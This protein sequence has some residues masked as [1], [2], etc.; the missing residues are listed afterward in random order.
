MAVKHT[1]EDWPQ[2]RRF[3]VR[4]RPCGDLKV[5]LETPD[6]IS[7]TSLSSLRARL[8]ELLEGYRVEMET[9]DFLPGNLAGKHRWIV[10][11]MASQQS[12]ASNVDSVLHL[13]QHT[14]AANR[15]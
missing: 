15:R 2:I 9:V 7:E 3:T 10:S 8:E 11:E 5:I 1:L 12:G 13:P 6:R 4:Q 14:G